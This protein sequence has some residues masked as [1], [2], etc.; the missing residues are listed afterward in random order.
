[1][2]PKIYGC[3]PQHGLEKKE[4][5]KILLSQQQ[6]QT[7]FLTSP[8]HLRQKEYYLR[9]ILKLL[10]NTNARLTPARQFPNRIRSIAI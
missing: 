8:S 6:V 10:K 4:R 2:D 1:M 5:K 3:R 9:V 7:L